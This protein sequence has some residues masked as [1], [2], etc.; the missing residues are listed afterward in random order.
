MKTISPFGKK[1]GTGTFDCLFDSEKYKSMDEAVSANDYVEGNYVDDD[2]T[3]KIEAH[4]I[5]E[6][7]EKKY[8]TLN[9]QNPLFGIDALDDNLACEM[10][11]GMFLKD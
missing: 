10:M 3:L 5:R 2:G 1:E 11:A 6:P 8:Y 9:W 7:Y 4:H